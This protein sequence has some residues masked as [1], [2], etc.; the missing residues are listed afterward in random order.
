MMSKH[1]EADTHTRTK[2]GGE[3]IPNT[4]ASAAQVFDALTITGVNMLL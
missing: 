2:S 3:N 4:D 1:R